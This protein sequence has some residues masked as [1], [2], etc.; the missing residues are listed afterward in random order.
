MA[1]P[2]AASRVE[3]RAVGVV[4]VDRTVD[5]DA[6]WTWRELSEVN[7]GG[8][9]YVVLPTLRGPAIYDYEPRHTF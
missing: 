9:V 1:P 6:E 8:C 7:L 4:D 5:D 2:I 3:V